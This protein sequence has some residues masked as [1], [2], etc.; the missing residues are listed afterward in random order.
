MLKIIDINGTVK[1]NNGVEMPYFGLGTFQSNEG[2]EVKNAIHYA[3]DAGYRLIDTASYY[4]NEKGVGE[5]IREHGIARDQVFITT[6]VWNDDQGYDQTLKAY[7]RSLK[8]LGFD[9]ADLYL[10]HW[11]VSG[12][13][14][15]T[16]KALE[17][18][19]NE[20]RVK[21][22]G[23][24]NFLK[25]HLNQ[26]LPDV[27]VMP[28]VNQM[29]FHPYLIQQELLDIC[30]E[31]KIEY[32]AWSPLMQGRVFDVSLLKQLAKKYNK[33]QVQIVLRWDL[34]RGVLTIP[35]SINQQ[36]IE[37]NANIFD[38]ELSSDDMIAIDALDRNHR[39]GYDPMRV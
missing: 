12:K 30:A 6:K 2:A 26:L 22:I 29:E 28:A 39:F 38:F 15:E 36:R 21:A 9:Y 3:L 14:K 23:I 31:N 5:A 25:I 24:S 17:R 37:D 11:P 35:K 32:Q 20:G 4:Q 7:D 19:Y 10:V 16:W 33:N 13:F 27:E 1:L 18:I 8:N 34:Q